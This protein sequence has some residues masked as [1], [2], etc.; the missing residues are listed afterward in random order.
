ML[1]YHVNYKVVIFAKSYIENLGRRKWRYKSPSNYNGQ[2]LAS[3]RLLIEVKSVLSIECTL[4]RL[5]IALTPSTNNAQLVNLLLLSAQSVWHIPRENLTYMWRWRMRA[6]N[7]D[8]ENLIFRNYIR[9]TVHYIG[10]CKSH[11][12]ELNAPHKYRSNK[13]NE[14]RVRRPFRSREFFIAVTGKGKQFFN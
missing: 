8:G 6:R 7:V 2:T 14:S 3:K 1:N 4:K 10:S 13:F 5:K 12:R 9:S 11:G